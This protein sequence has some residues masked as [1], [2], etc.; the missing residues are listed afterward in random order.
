MTKEVLISIKGLQFDGDVDSNEIEVITKADYYKKNGKHYLLYEEVQEGM[1]GTVKNTLKFK[2]HYMDLLR[3]GANNVHMIFDEENK[4]LS[5]YETPYGDIL[6]GIDTDSVKFTETEH[7]IRLDVEY[8][9]EV[10]YEHL[11]DCKLQVDIC[12]KDSGEFHLQ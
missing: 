10:N 9:L 4:T 8:S 1:D 6:I 5:N 12:A 7:R 2:E 11:S 3:Q